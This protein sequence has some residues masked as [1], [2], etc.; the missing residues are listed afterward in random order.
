MSI[1][2]ADSK[3]QQQ[4]CLFFEKSNCANRCMYFVFNEFCDSLNAQSYA[5]DNRLAQ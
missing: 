5:A 1:C 2:K 4:D 3:K